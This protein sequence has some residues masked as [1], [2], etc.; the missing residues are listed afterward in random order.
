MEMEH[1]N[2]NTIRVVIHNDDLVQRG[3]TFLDLLGNHR[4]I[5]N[6]FYSILEEVD[7]ED[8]FR[9]SEA[10]TF[11]VLPKGDGL[12]LFISK[13]I[14]PEDME[15]LENNEE[16]R[17]DV[18]EYL[19][20]QFTEDAESDLSLENLSS[21]VFEVADFEDLVQLA[22]E[23]YLD[24]AWTNLYRYKEGYY[25]Q[26]TFLQ[27]DLNV[28]DKEDMI[29]QVLEFANLSPITSEILA[30]HGQLLMERNAL[31]LLRYHFH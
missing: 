10:I 30:E 31:E 5:E 27:D 20:N 29:S 6:F 19:K 1:I 24:S 14:T 9:G 11:Q 16:F 2:D 17:D 22:A 12:E 7:I 28:M 25:L 26:I 18:A 13:N 21:L 4:E 23:V 8:E 15:G 3:I